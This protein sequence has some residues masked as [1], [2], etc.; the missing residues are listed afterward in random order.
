MAIESSDISFEYLYRQVEELAATRR[1]EVGVLDPYERLANLVIS[2]K[3][4]LLISRAKVYGID[5]SDQ[6]VRDE[7]LDRVTAIRDGLSDNWS[8]PDEDHE[9]GRYDYLN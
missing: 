1:G 9:A 4:E 2:R 3:G 8:Y 7:V 6:V 5:L